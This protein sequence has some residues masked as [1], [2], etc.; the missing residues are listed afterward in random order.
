MTPGD[1]ARAFGFGPF[2]LHSEIDLSDL[3]LA[4]RSTGIPVQ[5]R[6]EAVDLNAWT[7]DRMGAIRLDE[8]VVAAPQFC[9]LKVPGL[10]SFAVRGGAHVSV[11][12]EP[13]ADLRD[14]RGYLTAWVFGALCHQNAMLPLH[15]SAVAR[16]GAATAFLGESGAGKST[17]AAF[18]GRRG[19][20]LCSDD[21]CLLREAPEGMEVV[22][23]AEWLKLW[24]ETLDALDE[25]V[26]GANQ[27]FSDEDKYR[28]Y[29]AG[30]EAEAGSVFQAA[31]PAPALR[32][33]VFVERSE[34]PPRLEPISNAATLARMFG[35]VYLSYCMRGHA[36]RGTRGA[37]VCPGGGADA[38]LATYCSLGVGADAGSARPAGG[39]G[40]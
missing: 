37:A 13:H 31:E 28:V 18:L 32:H 3:R 38:G 16:E 19:Y 8:A 33:L 35:T 1:D 17:F 39:T 24:R 34:G 10:A 30:S 23:V 15:A 26:E 9:A 27:T 20:T 12:L 25:P 40:A 2:L 29:R 4:R 14:V 7:L 21:I 11:D 5:V 22:P 6:L 36:G